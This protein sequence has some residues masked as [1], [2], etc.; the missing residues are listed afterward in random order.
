MVATGKKQSREE[1]GWTGRRIERE[2]ERLGHG[3]KHRAE[4]RDRGRWGIYMRGDG[5]SPEGSS[6]RS[7][8]KEISSRTGARVLDGKWIRKHVYKGGA[9]FMRK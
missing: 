2:R 6:C 7:S 5:Y 8:M 3:C 1:T 4:K 9:S